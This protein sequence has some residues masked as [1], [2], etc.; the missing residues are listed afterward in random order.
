MLHDLRLWMSE[1]THASSIGQKAPKAYR[2]V[3]HEKMADAIL[4]SSVR[5]ATM[6][7]RRHIYA[8]LYRELAAAHKNVIDAK[9][10]EKRS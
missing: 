6:E 2:L 5:A 10:Q 9:V 7:M 4:H 8:G 1:N 3:N